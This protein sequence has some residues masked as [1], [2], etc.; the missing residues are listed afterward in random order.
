MERL[1]ETEKAGVEGNVRKSSKCETKTKTSIPA[2]LFLKTKE[3]ILY[4]S[5]ILTLPPPP[6]PLPKKPDISCFRSL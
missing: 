3:Y 4:Q 6:P 1:Q 5:L 2:Y